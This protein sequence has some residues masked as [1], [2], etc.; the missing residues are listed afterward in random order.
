MTR[1]PS[2]DGIPRRHTAHAY[3]LWRALSA[4]GAS[5]DMFLIIRKDW[6]QYTSVCRELSSR[7]MQEGLMPPPA[8]IS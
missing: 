3:S 7:K 8:W 5:A 2:K 1:L 4:H 6:R